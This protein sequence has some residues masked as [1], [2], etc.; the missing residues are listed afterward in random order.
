MMSLAFMVTAL[1]ES[2]DRDRLVR[3]LI[4]A[5]PEPHQ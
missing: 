5:M 4:H 2:G 3:L 1:A